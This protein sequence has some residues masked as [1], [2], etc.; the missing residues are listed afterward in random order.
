M[1]AIDPQLQAKLDAGATTLCRC[2]QVIR[3]D[4]QTFGFTDHDRDL[5]FDGET[6]LAG[7]GLDTSALESAVGLSVDNAQAVGA[8][9]SAGLMEDDITAGRFDSAKVIHWLVDWSDVDLRVLLFSGT[10]GEIKRGEHAFEVELRGLSE[11]LNRPVGRSF[12]RTCDRILGDAKCGFDLSQPGFTVTEA[13]FGVS[14]QRKFTLANLAGF[15]DEWFTHGAVL[16]QSGQ[17]SGLRSEIKFDRAVG[18]SREIEL[19]REAPMPIA[20]SDQCLLVA[21]CDKSAEACKGK[22]LNF[23]NFRGFPHIPGE[24]WAHAYPSNGGN[25]DGTSL[26]K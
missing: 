2:W 15:A 20:V 14:D 25:H 18:A 8:L 21:G 1:R 6:Y 24:D 13:V 10:L 11:G 9:S 16:W 19:W 23:N 12:G 7:S 4:G 26:W 3:S 22:F 5:A 17:N